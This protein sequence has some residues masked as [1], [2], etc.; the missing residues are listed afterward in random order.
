MV[1]TS[2]IHRWYILDKSGHVLTMSQP[3]FNDVSHSLKVLANVVKVNDVD[4]SA[5]KQ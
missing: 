3:C 5:G 4:I 2:L 1:D